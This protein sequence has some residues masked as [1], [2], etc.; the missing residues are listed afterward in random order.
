MPEPNAA[1]P[2]LV[3]SHAFWA[4]GPAFRPASALLAGES[5]AFHAR[6]ADAL[7]EVSRAH[8]HLAL[9]D[10]VGAALHL[11]GGRVHRGATSFGWLDCRFVITPGSDGS[12]MLATTPPGSW[13]R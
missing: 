8:E 12:G 2:S 9:P 1:A 11:P 7:G 13:A 3:F 5:G 6:V 10:L 4:A